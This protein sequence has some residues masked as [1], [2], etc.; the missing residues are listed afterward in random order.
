M[1]ADDGLCAF[2]LTYIFDFLHPK[3]CICRDADRLWS[4]VNN[5]HNWSSNEAFEEIVDFLV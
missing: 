5:D 4:H 1:L 2:L 3:V